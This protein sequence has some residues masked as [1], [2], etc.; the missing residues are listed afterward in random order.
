MVVMHCCGSQRRQVRS[1]LDLLVGLLVE[2]VDVQE[3]EVRLAAQLHLHG[4][5]EKRRQARPDGRRATGWRS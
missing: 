5:K 2:V 3:E 1:H 4:K